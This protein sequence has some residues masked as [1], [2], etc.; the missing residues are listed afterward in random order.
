MSQN[1][2]A[3]VAALIA[4]VRHGVPPDVQ[5]LLVYGAPHCGVP[6]GALAAVVDAVTED[7]GM[8]IVKRL[9]RL[10]A[11]AGQLEAWICMHTDFAS[12]PHQDEAGAKGLI[13][14][15]DRLKAERDA[16]R[17]AHWRSLPAQP[18]TTR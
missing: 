10:D 15:L 1:V 6:P 8:D 18:E 17:A 4:L 2:D 3:V 11:Q 7:A 14:A 12:P 5:E 16:L 13:A 9:R